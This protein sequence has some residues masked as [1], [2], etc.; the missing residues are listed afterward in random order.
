MSEQENP[1]PLILE[2]AQMAVNTIV[3]PSLV[4]IAEDLILVHTLVRQV[5]MALKGKH[6]TL[7]SIFN[8]LM[9]S[10]PV[11]DCTSD[12]QKSVNSS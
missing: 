7:F 8:T 12:N 11:A 2:T 5:Q 10:Y 6:P 3:N 9:Y 1:V 4:V